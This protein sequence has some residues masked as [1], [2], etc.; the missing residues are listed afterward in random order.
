MYLMYQPTNMIS[1][2]LYSTVLVVPLQANKEC[3]NAT[4]E[5]ENLHNHAH[6]LWLGHQQTL[7]QHEAELEEQRRQHALHVM[8]LEGEREAALRERDEMARR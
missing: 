4:Y 8:Q 6:K 2:K 1:T 7:K 3:N 5:L